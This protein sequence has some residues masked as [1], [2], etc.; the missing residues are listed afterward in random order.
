MTEE[1]KDF[2]YIV[3][4]AATDI[5]GDRP[6]RYALTRIRGVNF[7]IANA[8]LNHTG[9]GGKEKIGNM[10]DKDIEKLGTAIET[11]NEWL[12]DWMKNRSKD[13][14]TGKNIHIIG[15]EIDLNLRDDINLLRKVRSY[16]GIRHEKGLAL[17]GQRTRSN[18]RRGLTVGV[19]KRKGRV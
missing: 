4:I 13:M 8:I 19:V 3:R 7:M 1:N 12:P 14:F 2:K 15:S 16:R 9:L 18:K 6:T 11:L 17:R 10:K 5:D